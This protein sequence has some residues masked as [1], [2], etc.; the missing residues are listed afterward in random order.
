M[1]K[2]GVPIW[3]WSLIKSVEFTKGIEAFEQLDHNL[4]EILVDLI[5]LSLSADCI[6]CHKDIVSLSAECTRKNKDMVS[7]LRAL[8]K[9]MK[10]WV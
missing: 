3:A 8:A 7:A 2:H 4:L 10:D 9:A 6:R 5:E 1:R